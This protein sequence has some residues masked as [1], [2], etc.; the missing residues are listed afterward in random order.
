M[1]RSRFSVAGLLIFG[2]IKENSVRLGN[3]LL[4]SKV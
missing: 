2:V 1:N 4:N 3:K